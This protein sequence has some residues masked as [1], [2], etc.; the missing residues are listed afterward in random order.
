[1]LRD[2]AT[3]LL[4]MVLTMTQL[5]ESQTTQSVLVGRVIDSI[6]GVPVANAAVACVREETTEESKARVGS[7]GDYA[8]VSL[9]SGRYMVTV[10]AP[11]YQSQQA[12]ALEVPVAGR[13]ELNFRLRP[14]YDLWESR[15]PNTWI[16]PDS[17]Q[18]LS[19]YGL[20]VDV[21]RVAVFNANLGRV[22]PLESSRSD[23]IPATYIDNLPLT[24]RDVYTM[25][26]L[27]PGVTADTATARGLGFSVNG[28]RPSSSNY[29]LDGLENNSLLVTGPLTA[30]L[31]EFVQEYR[32]STSNFSAEYGRTS[33]FITNAI[34]RS[35]TNRLHGTVFF[36]LKNEGLNANGFQENAQGV[37]RAPLREYQPGGFVAGPIVRDRLFFSAGAHHSR[38][39]SESDPQLFN[40][41]T[42]EF[43][44]A[45]D[46]NSYAGKLLRAY[47]PAYAPTGVPNSGLVSY[48]PP[49]DF[50][51]SGGLLRVDGYSQSRAQHFF[52]RIALDRIYQPALLPSPYAQLS[53][54]Y[55]Q[56]ALSLAAAL[57]SRWGATMTNELR[58]ARTG[59]SEY[60]QSPHSEV[61]FLEVDQ[62]VGAGG[63]FYH[64]SLPGAISPFNYRNRGRNW[65]VLDNW[66]RVS[67]RHALKA[68]AGFLQRAVNLELA[69]YPQGRFEFRTLA[70]FAAGT[71]SYLYTEVDKFTGSTNMESPKRSY[72][73][74]QTYAFAQDSYHASSRLTFDYGVRYEYFGSP[75]NTGA[76]KDALV[77]LGSGNSI[78]S[79]IAAAKEVLPAA[80]GGQAIY[81]SRPSNWAARAGA[82]WDVAGTGRT[83]LR[84]SYGIFY[85]R[86]FDN[87]WE[88]LIQN[89][90]QTRTY[91]IGHAVDLSSPL[92]QIE[93]AATPQSSS[94]IVNT[95]AFQPRLRAPRVQ[96]AFVS[97]Q[98]KLTPGMMLEISGIA[99][100]GKQLITTDDVN[101][102]Y[103]GPVDST[104][105]LGYL[106]PAFADIDYRANQGSSDYTAI[107][108]SL[109]V[110]RKRLSG[111]VSYTLSHSIDNQSESLAGTFFDFNQFAGASK[112]A[113]P[114][115]SSFTR[116][117][118]SGLDR[119]NSDFD[120]RQNLVFLATYESPRISA[121]RFLSALTRDW[122]ASTL[123][124]VRS[125]LPFTVY[126]PVNYSGSP[127]EILINQRANLVP[128]L[129]CVLRN[130][131][132]WRPGAFE[133]GG[134]LERQTEHLGHE[135]TQC[136]RWAWAAEYR[137]FTCAFLPGSGHAGI[138]ETQAPCRFLQPP[139]PCESEQPRFLL[140]F[141]NLR[142]RPVRPTRDQ[143]RVPSAQPLE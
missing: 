52:A 116:E 11:D 81:S 4:L 2:K 53:N 110:R 38:S 101:R 143:Q 55:R 70:D 64:V 133:F 15:Q 7:D 18:A 140:W 127:P 48:S 21:S 17:Q 1:M 82:A 137:F 37:P 141:P 65:E 68:G 78:Q 20:D 12:R 90:Y 113:Y 115:F 58:A 56:T 139:E 28:Q 62:G 63:G 45:T 36:N 105:V 50:D 3:L 32:V 130:R 8:F 46:P 102:P 27:L 138:R 16:A 120:Q 29:L 99:S 87:L 114:Y 57:L 103:S 142:I 96:S 31:P 77:L 131:R 74:G 13:V 19:F 51:R 118:A 112:A 124:A 67:G 128:A 25:L 89:R 6:T 35:G 59:D 107:T 30:A 33:G 39:R 41:P 73:Y 109:R 92:S 95:L 69:V 108:A 125:G 121:R 122:T 97:L 22:T 54:P 132:K 83:L 14:T 42:R 86:L 44:N 72:R 43:V 93:A 129:R 85:D 134:V 119:G 60:L 111:Q 5:A 10:S 47:L 106:N 79:S 23:V 34:T 91:V 61:P 104:N 75:M 123:G 88:N 98:Q 117:F 94:Q 126:G 76:Q 24:G 136:F 84:A 100:R 40:L 66:T 80:S 49:A 9:S 135:W 71:P 26:V